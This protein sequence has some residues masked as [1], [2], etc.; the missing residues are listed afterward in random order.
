MK[1]LEEEFCTITLKVM[2]Q[3]NALNKLLDT[4][5]VLKGLVASVGISTIDKPCNTLTICCVPRKV[6]KI[7]KI[8]KGLK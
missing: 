4:N 8:I 1:I 3:E 2:R 7:L 6:K 5:G